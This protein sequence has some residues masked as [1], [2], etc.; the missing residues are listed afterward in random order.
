VNG[1]SFGS[2]IGN[3]GGA[4]MDRTREAT[5]KLGSVPA[6]AKQFAENFP[7]SISAPEGVVEKTSLT[8]RLKASPDT[9]L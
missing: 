9:N 8:A 6:A 1:L 2:G 4:V 7:F 3:S 5:K